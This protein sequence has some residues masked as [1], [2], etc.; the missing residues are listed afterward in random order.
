MPK[1]PM[2]PK[3]QKTANFYLKGMSM[4]QAMLKA[5]YNESYAGSQAP[6]FLK[7]R[8]MI[9]YIRQRQQDEA[10][11]ELADAIYTKKK[12]MDLVASGDP[13]LAIPA[14]KLLDAH[15]KWQAELEA[16]FAE[17]E[18]KIKEPNDSSIVINI[19]EAKKED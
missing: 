6:Q 17:I 8:G 19:G 2:T 5:G 1:K 3:Q 16:K 4:R 12:L 18:N 13:E 10:D 15:N 7:N 11:A 14:L 9:E